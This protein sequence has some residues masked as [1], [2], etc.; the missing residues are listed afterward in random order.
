MKT[1]VTMPQ[2]AY[3]LPKHFRGGDV[4]MIDGEAQP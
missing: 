3:R 2:R 4:M 1:H